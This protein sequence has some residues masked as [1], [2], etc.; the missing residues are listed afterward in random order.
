MFSR[1]AFA[2]V[3]KQA[4]LT[5]Y[6]LAALYGVSRQSIYDWLKGDMPKAGGLLSRMADALPVVLLAAV[7][8]RALPMPPVDKAVRKARIA[9]MQARLEKLPAAPR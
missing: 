2:R 8:K 4:G 1:E 5:K 7:T 9:R 3:V 6:E